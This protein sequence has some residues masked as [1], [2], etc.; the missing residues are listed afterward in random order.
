[1]SLLTEKLPT[2]LMICGEVCPINTD[3]R[4][5][6]KFSGLMQSDEPLTS[7]L[8]NMFR[9]IFGENL[10]PNLEDGLKAVMEFYSPLQRKKT[11]G[12]KKSERSVYDFDY[13]AE[14]IAAAFMQQYKIDLSTCELHWHLFRAYF[15]A[16]TEDTKFV[17]VL[18]YRSLKL[19]TIKDKQMKKHY[20]ELKMM[21]MLP[22]NRTEQEKEDALNKSFAE[23]FV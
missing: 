6:I 15:D 18:G 1:M 7:K 16:L 11:R 19:S 10:P 3:F 2:E 20:R 23:L 17:K 22:D 5:W 14:L 12:S 4:I 8:V 13:D 9:L 21:Y